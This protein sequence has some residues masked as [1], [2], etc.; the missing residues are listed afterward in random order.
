M[1][2]HQLVA[3]S[4]EA[5]PRQEQVIRGGGPLTTDLASGSCRSASCCAGGSL[6]R[7][8]LHHDFSCSA[9]TSLMWGTETFQRCKSKSVFL[10]LVALMTYFG[11]GAQ[12]S[13]VQESDTREVCSLLRLNLTY[14]S[15]ALELLVEGVQ[16]NGQMLA[17]EGPEF[18]K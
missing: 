11:G 2:L 3:L 8:V 14:G 12:R 18:C 6:H 16:N 15:R 10:Y 13:A 4:G 5:G 1:L 9:M 17:A 7:T